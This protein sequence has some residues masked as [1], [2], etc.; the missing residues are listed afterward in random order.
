MASLSP[1]GVQAAAAATTTALLLFVSKARSG[2]TPNILCFGCPVSGTH[3]QSLGSG[4]GFSQSR[5]HS[6][7]TRPAPGSRLGPRFSYVS[8]PPAPG[9]PASSSLPCLGAHFLYLALNVRLLRVPSLVLCS[10]VS[11]LILVTS[12]FPAVETTTHVLMTSRFAAQAPPRPCA[13]HT[14]PNACWP[15]RSGRSPRVWDI[16]TTPLGLG[17]SLRQQAV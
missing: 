2:T 8:P 16:R 10:S 4:A 1:G 13:S 7:S 17:Q 6:T 9:S 5:S 12:S 3:P 14:G 15:P 11:T